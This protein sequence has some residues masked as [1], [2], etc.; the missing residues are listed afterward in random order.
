MLA[1]MPVAVGTVRQ[2]GPSGRLHFHLRRTERVLALSRDSHI[3]LQ[4]CDFNTLKLIPLSFPQSGY[5]SSRLLKIWSSP[6]SGNAH[7]RSPCPR[8]CQNDP[9]DS[10]GTL[11][12]QMKNC[13]PFVKDL[14]S[15]SNIGNTSQMSQKSLK[16]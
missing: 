14:L 16:I 7:E 2:R 3:L 9:N 11:K 15:I 10:T 12:K 6:R 4:T 1:V 13:K 8:R 5:P